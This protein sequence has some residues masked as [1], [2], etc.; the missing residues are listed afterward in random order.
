MWGK[1]TARWDGGQLTERLGRRRRAGAAELAP[2]VEVSWFL[3]DVE[4]FLARQGT[5]HCGP[6]SQTKRGCH[7][8]LLS[9]VAVSRSHH[10]FGRSRLVVA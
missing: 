2:L 7:G 3:P 4:V 1:D 8:A 10:L 9:V 5:L 6:R